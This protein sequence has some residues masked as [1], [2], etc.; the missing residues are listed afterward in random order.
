MCRYMSCL[1]IKQLEN[2]N[3]GIRMKSATSENVERCSAVAFVDDIDLVEDGPKAEENMQNMI[4]EYD[5]LHSASGGKIEIKKTKY[6]SWKW[7]WRQG[8]KIA[9]SMPIDLNVKNVKV[10]ELNIN[11]GIRSLEAC[12][13]PTLK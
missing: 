4:K 12:M 7:T 3:Y 9:K 2:K 13:P 11:E 8:V 6:F 1:M 5:D 10:D